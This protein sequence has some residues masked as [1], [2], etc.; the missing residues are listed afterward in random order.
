MARKPQ[1]PPQPIRW[2]IHRAAK[3]AV[4]VGEVEAADEREA[5]ETAAAEHICHRRQH[6]RRRPHLQGNDRRGTQP[7]VVREAV[8]PMSF[9]VAITA[10]ALPRFC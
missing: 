10:I 8:A 1:G 3:K 2:T 9:G 7:A 6:H 4:W 5:I